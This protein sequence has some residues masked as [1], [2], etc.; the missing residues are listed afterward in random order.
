MINA[1]IAPAKY[2]QYGTEVPSTDNLVRYY[3]LYWG[4]LSDTHMSEMNGCWIITGSRVTRKELFH[5]LLTADHWEDVIFPQAF[6][7][8]MMQRGLC[9]FYIP[10]N[11]QIAFIIYKSLR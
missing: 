4:A 11:G 7:Y 3:N 2:K 1:G 8:I 5:T 6:S 10:I 9:G